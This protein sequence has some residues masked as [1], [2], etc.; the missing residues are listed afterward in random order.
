MDEPIHTRPGQ[1]KLA[2]DRYNTPFVPICVIIAM[3]PSYSRIDHRARDK[4]VIRCLEITVVVLI[5]A[6]LIWLLWALFTGFFD[7]SSYSVPIYNV[8]YV[9]TAYAFA[10][11]KSTILGVATNTLQ[12]IFP[13][14]ILSAQSSVDYTLQ[15]RRIQRDRVARVQRLHSRGMWGRMIPSRTDTTLLSAY[16]SAGRRDPWPHT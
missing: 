5:I 11:R 9:G 16:H 13:S 1:W 2:L 12:F 14:F 8:T 15:A 6:F 3:A 4:N 7:S 10:G